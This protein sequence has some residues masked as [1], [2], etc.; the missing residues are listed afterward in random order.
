MRTNPH[1]LGT[2][3]LVE[4]QGLHVAVRSHD[5]RGR[6][7]ASRS[8]RSCW[9]SAD[10][11]GGRPGPR[12]LARRRHA[13]RVERHRD[14]KHDPRREQPQ[15]R[16]LPGT[17]HVERRTVRLPRRLPRRRRPGLPRRPR[18]L[19]PARPRR[20]RRHRRRPAPGGAGGLPDLGHRTDGRGRLP[21][22]SDARRRRPPP[23]RRR[24]P[25]RAI[26]PERPSADRRAVAWREDDRAR[27]RRRTST[28]ATSPR[29]SR[30]WDRHTV[31]GFAR[32]RRL[33]RLRRGARDRPRLRRPALPVR[34]RRSAACSAWPAGS[35]T[36]TRR[37]TTPRRRPGS[38][39]ASRPGAAAGRRVLGGDRAAPRLSGRAPPD[40]DA[41]PD[42]QA[43]AGRCVLRIRTNMECYYDQAFIA[44]RDAE[45]ESAPGRRRCPSPGRSLGHR[46]LHARGLARRPPAAA[47]RLRLRRPRPAGAAV[48]P[49]DPLRRRG[50]AAR[51]PTT[52]SS[53]SSAPA[54]RSGSSSTPWTFPR[55]PKAGPAATSSGASATAR[56]P[57]RSPPAATPSALA[58][59]GMPDFPFA[60]PKTSRPRDPAYE[61]Y[62]ESTRPVQRGRP[63]MRGS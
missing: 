59:E 31:D 18:R 47:L 5:A 48:G 33:D 56:T 28:A 60:D 53:A 46:G 24:P 17:F 58:L 38:R 3:V 15:D 54:T 1:G 63:G 45:A 37:R 20:G 29:P 10:R 52:T 41:R 50:R 2:R 4:G 19:R 49:A 23:R 21:R 12:P 42:R 43:G 36:P 9:G 16:E 14:Q 7:S 8:P 13:V 27:S 32:S 40:D 44:V 51:R 55:S 61:Q 62:L 57:T 6:A 30:H 26:R 22:S 35:S 34:P 11:A 25:R 39:S